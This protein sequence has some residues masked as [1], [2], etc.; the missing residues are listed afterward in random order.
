MG[1]FALDNGENPPVP[2]HIHIGTPSP[3]P[4]L[5]FVFVNDRQY[6]PSTWVTTM[7]AHMQ[8]PYFSS[9]HVRRDPDP[10]RGVGPVGESVLSHSE[11]Q[12]I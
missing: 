8:P 4:W 7:E 5:A 9:H 11:M 6:D 1:T 3:N 2:R 12:L 10:L